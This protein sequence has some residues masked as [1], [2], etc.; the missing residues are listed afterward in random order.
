MPTIQQLDQQYGIGT[1][2]NQPQVQQPRAVQN[3]GEQMSWL[4]GVAG[5]A[6]QVGGGLLG[7]RGGGAGVK[8]GQTVGG[9][10][11]QGLGEAIRE[12]LTHQQL[13]PTSIANQTGQGLLWSLLPGGNL[14]KGIGN[15]LLRL[16]AKGVVRGVGGAGVGAATQAM[17][18]VQQN[19]PVGQN[20]PQTALETGGANVAFGGLS[21]IL[22]AAGKVLN[23][24]P[25]DVYDRTVGGTIRGLQALYNQ[26]ASK[27]VGD[28][29]LNYAME[30]GIIPS[31]TD[32]LGNRQP[33]GLMTKEY[34]DQAVA[35]RKDVAQQVEDKLQ[36][37][38]PGV[39]ENP[40]QLHSIQPIL[41]SFFQSMYQADPKNVLSQ[42]ISKQLFMSDILKFAKKSTTSDP[43]NT[44]DLMG[45]LAGSNPGSVKLINDL[46][47]IA[48]RGFS[49]TNPGAWNGLYSDLKSFVEQNATDPKAVA[50]LNAE[51]SMLRNIRL[52]M[53]D[54]LK[55]G[56][57]FPVP[58]K[59]VM[60]TAE[61]SK[62]GTTIGLSPTRTLSPALLALHALSEGGAGLG[63]YELLN[64]LGHVGGAASF[65][66]AFLAAGAMR[67][68]VSDLTHNPDFLE[69]TAKAVLAGQKLS[70]SGTALMKLIQ[71]AAVR[72]PGAANQGMFN[73]QGLPGGNQLTQ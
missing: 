68:L 37:Y 27:F 50:N 19:K 22:S 56:A 29:P 40:L 20:V 6:G 26:T 38:L 2:G 21:D 25:G 73:Q 14:A 71:Q 5:V 42:A 69:N 41:D 28:Y 36:S 64:Q 11:G 49:E 63:V 52:S 62:Y 43:V 15:P 9:S 17:Q 16:G 59:Q 51:H 12:L 31:T 46:K 65:G 33:E 1:T 8:V 58:E 72:T 66:G 35:K 60:D 55:P 61:K 39:K 54:F 44:G 48:G 70:P 13:N 47:R 30:K 32:E 3:P 18:N 7:L 45:F 10:A 57:E 4:P 67:L 23:K 53:N 24:I 34:I